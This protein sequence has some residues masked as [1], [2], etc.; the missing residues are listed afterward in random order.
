MSTAPK[1]QQARSADEH[2]REVA[3]EIMTLAQ[4]Y[5]NSGVD[6]EEIRN[7]IR[8]IQMLTASLM[9]ALELALQPRQ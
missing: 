8:G 3:F 4:S 5:I 2:Y 7:A 1:P 6:N 9:R